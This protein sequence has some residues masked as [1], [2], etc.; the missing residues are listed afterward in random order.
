MLRLARATPSQPT[1]LTYLQCLVPMHYS[2]YT[3]TRPKV[4]LAKS[5]DDSRLP[6]M[7]CP[8]T[9]FSVNRSFYSVST[10]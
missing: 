1:S 9:R 10:G 7:R 6:P 3:E 2:G 8:L 5:F 4:G